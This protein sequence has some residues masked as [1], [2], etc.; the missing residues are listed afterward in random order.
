MNE[1]L[2]QLAESRRHLLANIAHELGTP[3][4]IVKSYI[5]AVQE[6]LISKTD[7]F[8]I[9]MLGD[10]VHLLDRLIEDLFDLSKL[11][12]GQLTLKLNEIKVN[13]LTEGLSKKLEINV[14][15]NGRKFLQPDFNTNCLRSYHCIADKDRIDQVFSNLVWNAI[16]HTNKSNGTISF[17]AK[18]QEEANEVIYEVA[19]NGS[20]ISAEELPYI[21]ERFYKATM[22]VSGNEVDGSGLGL[23]IVKEIVEVHG[24]RIWVESVLHEG[25]KFYVALPVQYKSLD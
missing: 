19:D 13:Q 4:T 21:F 15:Q 8:Y 14:I 10:K 23:A 25:S 24:G 1:N 22:K 3:V 6:G 2:I 5:Q 12:A 16:K 7:S 20:G 9:R 11:E 18:V 17:Q